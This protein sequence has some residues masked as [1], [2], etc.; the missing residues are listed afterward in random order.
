MQNN[1]NKG[2]TIG[3]IITFILM[4]GIWMSTNTK[5]YLNETYAFNTVRTYIQHGE[6]NIN[7]KSIYICLRRRITSKTIDPI[8]LVGLNETQ[9]ENLAACLTNDN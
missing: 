6:S 5:H 2:L 9:S 7:A 3:V 8:D 1:F 4:A